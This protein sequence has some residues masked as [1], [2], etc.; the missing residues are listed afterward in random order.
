MG[1][2]NSRTGLFC[3]REFGKMISFGI[4]EKEKY[5]WGIRENRN[6]WSEMRD[7]DFV[8][9]FFWFGNSD[10]WKISFRNPGIDPCGEAS[11]T[12]FKLQV[13]FFENWNDQLSQISPDADLWKLCSFPKLILLR[14][15]IL[16][17]FIVIWTV[18]SLDAVR[19]T[20][21]RKTH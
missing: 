2:Q 14:T 8:H 3:V 20:V 4:Q 12:Q 5:R 19:N 15:T 9:D 17:E 7:N 13:L 18:T 11:L 21:F 6:I 10:K 16:A 1:F